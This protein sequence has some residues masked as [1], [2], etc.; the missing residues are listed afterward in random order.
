HRFERSC[1]IYTTVF[2]CDVPAGLSFHNFSNSRTSPM[3][4]HFHFATKTGC[5]IEPLEIV[6]Q[7]NAR[8]YAEISIWINRTKLSQER[9]VFVNRAALCTLKVPLTR[10]GTITT[11]PV[12]RQLLSE[13]IAW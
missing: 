11:R 2:A 10:P 1:R 8:L 9:H 4:A 6:I 5:G 3:E 13:G 7:T 12:A